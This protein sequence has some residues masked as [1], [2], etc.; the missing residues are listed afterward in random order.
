MSML[1]KLKGLVKGHEGTVR[2]GMDKAGDVVD[3]TTGG[4]YSRQ[5]D[6]AKQKMHQQ[7]G[8]DEP[9]QGEERPPQG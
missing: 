6:S 4:R 1:E 8:T 5:V 7:L 9:G 2:K 3:R